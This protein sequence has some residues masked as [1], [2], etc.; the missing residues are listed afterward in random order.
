LDRESHIEHPV[1]RKDGSTFFVEVHGRTFPG[2]GMRFSALRD[3]TERKEAEDALRRARDELERRVQE[4]T[5]ELEHRARQLARLS[6]ELTLAE[7]GE[8]QRLAQMLHDHLQQLLAGAKFGL[9]LMLRKADVQQR[10]R[11]Q[12]VSELLDESIKACRALTAELS[13]PILHEAGL[14]AGLQWLVRWMDEKHGLKIDMSLDPDVPA[15]RE[16]VRVLLFQSVRELLFNIVK[17]AGTRRARLELSR[18]DAGHIRLSVRDEGAGFSPGAMSAENEPATAGGFGLFSIRERLHLLGG[19]LDIDTAPGRGTSVTMVAPVLPLVA[20]AG[21]PDVTVE[22]HAEGPERT[23]ECAIPGR[24][25]LLL[26]DD[27]AVMRQGLLQLLAGE[28]DL[29]I[30]GQAS[31]GQEA[32]EQARRLHPDVIL[33]DSSMPRMDG[34]QATRI[35]HAEHPDV[36]II[37]LS[38]YEEADRASAMLAAG[39]SAYLTKSGSFDL[40]LSTIR[41]VTTVHA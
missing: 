34:I 10:G 4:R 15:Q 33:M 31:D 35:I 32:V 27:H 37:G 29:C 30:L 6:S 5:R 8:R 11:A 36:Y 9:E 1:L 24:I 18:H 40:L 39:A 41:R 14:A 21:K 22:R 16:D 26:V 23:D 19:C 17:H 28:E 7:Q 25:C 2:D 38:M 13:P 20:P 3:V 12:R